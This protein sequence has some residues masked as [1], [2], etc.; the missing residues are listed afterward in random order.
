MSV[1]RWAVAILATAAVPAHAAKLTRAE[2]VE[3]AARQNPQVAAARAQIAKVEAQKAQADAARWPEIT[4]QAATGP[5]LRAELVPGTSQSTESPYDAGFDDLSILVGGQLQVLQ[6]LYT[7]G[8]IDDRREAAEHGIRA[9]TAESEIT[10]Q[11]VAL[12]A[13]RL[14]EG[15]LFAR[16]AQRFMEEIVHYAERTLE[17]ARQ[18]SQVQGSTITEADVLRLTSALKA[19]QMGGHRA[20]AGVRQAEAGLRAYL[21]LPE[22]EPLEPGNET[23]EPLASQATPVEQSVATALDRRPE[24]TALREGIVAYQKLADAERAAYYPDFFVLGAVS[25]VYTHDRDLLENRYLIDP[26]YHFVPSVLLGVRWT[27]QAD[28]AGARGE[29]VRAEAQRLQGLLDWARQGV[30]AEVRKASEDAERARRDIEAAAQGVEAAKKWAVR[31]DLDFAAGL[32]DATSVTDAVTAYTELRLAQLDA[33]Y[34]LNTA[35]AELARATGTL[36]A[37][38]GP[39]T[40]GTRP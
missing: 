2:V 30:P 19:A 22:D 38:E 14:Y 26:L 21:G 12:E 3:R 20:V 34:R 4:L 8:K 15:W 13:A 28:M 16:E 6:P 25:A 29:E 9:R 33:V 7:F 32:T 24:L 17:R 10:S 11:Q 40:E 39:Y 18:E 5:S 27:V 35:L 31:A 37:P 23:L 1:R 36:G